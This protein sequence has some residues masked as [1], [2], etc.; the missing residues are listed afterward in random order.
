MIEDSDTFN[1][2][3]TILKSEPLTVDEVN[4][5]GGVGTENNHVNK[6]TSESVGTARRF[7]GYGGMAYYSSDTCGYVDGNYITSDC[8]IGYKDS[9]V[10]YVLDNWV[11]DKFEL[12]DLI[13]DLDGYFARLIKNEELKN[14]L[15]CTNGNCKLSSFDW[16][17]KYMYWIFDLAN[18]Y[19]DSSYRSL[20]Q[21]NGYLS[22]SNMLA[23]YVNVRPVVTL[24]KS[25][26]E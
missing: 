22:V 11:I 14:N 1:E 25:A 6:Y 3:V 13:V 5:Y 16:T 10:K 26:L 7:Y 9:D 23:T 17:Y 19:S 8:S 4:L 2:S 21:S 18:E 12:N 15:G 20:C 24:K